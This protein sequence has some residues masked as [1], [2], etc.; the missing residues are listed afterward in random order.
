MMRSSETPA[1][2]HLSIGMP[3]QM[4]YG[5]DQLLLTGICKEAVQEVYLTK[6]GFRGDGIADVRYHGGPD[7]AVCVYPYEHYEQWDREF[8]QA[9]P[10]AAFGENLTLSHM[11]EDA[12]CIGDI[13]QIGDAVVQIT[14]G[15]VPCSTITKRLAI[16]GMLKRMTETGYTGYLCRVLEEGVVCSD[17]AIKLLEPHPEQ[18]SILFANQMY[19]QKQD[20][21]SGIE[22]VLAVDALADEWRISLNKRLS[23]IS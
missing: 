16:P 14:Q 20:K 23:Q 19:Y 8:G 13:Y 22:R 15:R 12:V 5:Q 17:S 6:D 4:S 3:K 7:R 21:P 10:T 9:L 18:I 1:I 2:I 11:T